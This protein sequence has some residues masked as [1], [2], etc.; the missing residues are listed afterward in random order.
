MQQERCSNSVSLGLQRSKSR[1]G[2]NVHLQLKEEEQEGLQVPPGY[3]VRTSCHFCQLELCSSQ[4]LCMHWG[5]AEVLGSSA[6]N[7]P[8]RAIACGFLCS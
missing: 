7:A 4:L 6:M 1:G 3:V 2:S 5:E 8:F